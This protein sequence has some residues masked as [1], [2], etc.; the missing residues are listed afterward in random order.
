MLEQT[1]GVMSDTFE[2]RLEKRNSTIPPVNG[3]AREPMLEILRARLCV[4]MRKRR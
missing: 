3:P 4:P 2:K 1:S